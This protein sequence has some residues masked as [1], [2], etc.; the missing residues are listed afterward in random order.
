MNS[1]QFIPVPEGLR[2]GVYNA[3][4]GWGPYSERQISELFRTYGF[5]ETADV[6]DIGGVRRSTAEQFQRCI[7]WGDPDQR[8]RYLM[9][10][11]EVL[12][13]YPDSDGVPDPLARNV[14]R[15]IALAQVTLPGGAP[16][17]PDSADDLWRPAGSVRVFMSHLSGKKSAVHSLARVLEAFGFSAFVAHDA[18][19]PSRAW[20]LE[21]ERALRSCDL[22]VAYVS[23]GFRESDWTDQEVGWALGRDLI[24]IP[25]SAEG[26]MPHGFLGSY[27]AVRKHD[28]QEAGAL[29]RE[30]FKAI[31][32]ATFR[33][34]RPRAAE[35][36]SRI[37]LLIT[38]G[39]SRSSS[40]DNTRFWFEMIEMIPKSTWTTEMRL[41]VESALTENRQVREAVLNEGR[42]PVPDAI[43]A[44]L[45]AV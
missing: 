15:A 33:P 40:F 28:A 17:A 4:G 10:V 36:D 27:Q 26:A 39:F 2:I 25:V 44:L 35:L 14:R 34:Q 6:G 45:E 13:N 9:L 24:T 41:Q 31:S 19:R 20:L 5:A 32:D 7:D 12:Q 18:I 16:A 23:P 38:A 8:R 11:E 30:V 43:R 3:M 22:L 42:G 21:I 29:G 1:S 37:G